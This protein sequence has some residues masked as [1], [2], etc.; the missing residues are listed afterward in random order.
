LE[1]RYENRNDAIAA[2]QAELKTFQYSGRDD[3]HDQWWGRNDGV[4][5]SAVSTHET[6]SV[7]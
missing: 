4:I 6:E 1:D 5:L 7:N 2:I 3:Q